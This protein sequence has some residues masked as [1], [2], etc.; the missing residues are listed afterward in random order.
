MEEMI[1]TE[2]LTK[3]YHGKPVV[4]GVKLEVPKKA[5]YGFLGPNGAGK[6]TTMK[7]LLGLVRPDEGQ[8][9]INGRPM[10][11]KSR[12]EILK[13]TGSLIE[14]PS[15]YGNLTAR[16]NLKISCLLR[17]LPETEIDRVLEI[18]RLKGQEKKKTAHFSLGMKQRLGLANA[19]QWAGP[20]GNP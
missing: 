18:V 8:I 17:N 12:V 2:N 19:Y 20:C 14:N 10:E 4:D 13:G 1:R 5:I 16:E 7:M 15:Y 6:S 9:W 11:E 3:C